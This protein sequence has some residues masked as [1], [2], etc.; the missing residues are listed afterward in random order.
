[1]RLTRSV[2]FAVVKNVSLIRVAKSVHNLTGVGQNTITFEIQL[3]SSC[4]DF[5]FFLL[6]Q[7]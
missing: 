4:A 6:A 7:T 3:K 2:N 5:F 1:M